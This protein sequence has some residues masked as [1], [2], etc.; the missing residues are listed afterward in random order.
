MAVPH[1]R[2]ASSRPATVAVVHDA[3]V[4]P[5]GL[6]QV[7]EALRRALG[8]DHGP[9]GRGVRAVG[10]G[11]DHQAA[12]MAVCAGEENAFRDLLAHPDR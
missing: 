9:Y 12:Q 2:A 7:L 1:P 10:Q 5:F 8:P 4:A 11:A 6:R 3:D